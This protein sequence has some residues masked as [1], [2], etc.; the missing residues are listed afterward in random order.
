M[1]ILVVDDKA[2]IIENVS[3]ILKSFGFDVD[4]ANNGLAGYEQ[5]LK[6]HYDLIIVDH[7]MPIMN[8]IKMVKSIRAKQETCMIPVLLMTTQ[9]LK[10][11]ENLEEYMLF[12]DVISKPI[13]KS[14]FLSKVNS[15]LP[16]NT[17][18][19]SL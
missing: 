1:R 15:L 3:M 13:E 5:A 19:Q 8:G 18:C 11:V 12:N 16:E 10:D 7:L 9:E 4:T 17:L 14:L 2:N 6:V